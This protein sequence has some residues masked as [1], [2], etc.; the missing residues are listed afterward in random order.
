MN[1]M[2][3]KNLKKWGMVRISV[4]FLVEYGKK[5]E[6]STFSLYTLIMK[7]SAKKRYESYK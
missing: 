2:F 7:N 1:L 3:W 5:T 4:K 6:S